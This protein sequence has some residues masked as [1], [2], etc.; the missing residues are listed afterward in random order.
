ML[1]RANLAGSDLARTNL[2]SATLDQASL[3]EASLEDAV[4]SRCRV[5]GVSCWSSRGTPRNQDDLVITAPWR[6]D[7]IT[8]DDIRVAQ[9]VHLLLE[10]PQIRTVID[11]VAQKGVLIL[12]RFTADR[13]IVL[14]GLRN[15]LRQRN[16]V[17]FVFDFERP[18]TRD[19]SE[20]VLI[21]AGMSLFVIAD[22]TNPRSA[23]MELQVT[24][25]NYMVR[26]VPILEEGEQAFSMLRDLQGK[27]D[28][29]LP[30]LIYDNVSTLL[31]K[32]DLAIIGPALDAVK[33]IAERRV[34]PVAPRHIRDFT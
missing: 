33:R 10:N 17:P 20:T 12:G 23:P 28:W 16:L 31:E 14:D 19:F 21:L 24:V 11:T 6:Q 7:T 5:Y 32:L 1:F 18:T 34:R 27:F 2:T 3:V 25:P 22:I 26:Y 9:F 13:K 29:V 15:A 4:L 8:V 30:E